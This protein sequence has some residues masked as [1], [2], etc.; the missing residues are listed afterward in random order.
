MNSSNNREK[1]GVRICLTERRFPGR[2]SRN[3][4]RHMNLDECPHGVRRQSAAATAL[5]TARRSLV[6]A[7]RPACLSV[8]R[9]RA[10][11]ATAFQDA[12]GSTVD[13]KGRLLRLLKV[14][15]LR[16]SIQTLAQHP[17]ELDDVEGFGNKINA[18]FQ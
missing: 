6:L 17:G 18:L 2:S 12:S 4:A 7:E 14:K 1:R 15:R 13:G 3:S 5:W 10:S 11:L 8:K 9:C 16:L